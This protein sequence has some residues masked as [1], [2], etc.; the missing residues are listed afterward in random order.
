MRFH[1]TPVTLILRVGSVD[2]VGFQR[3]CEHAE[4]ESNSAEDEDAA[5]LS[6][7]GPITR[8]NED[9]L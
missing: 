9:Q 7:T 8:S 5:L 6:A 1:K 4:S 2:S 3:A